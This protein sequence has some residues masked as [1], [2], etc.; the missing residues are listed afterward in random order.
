MGEGKSLNLHLCLNLRPTAGCEATAE[1]IL[2]RYAFTH[3]TLETE[4]D[5]ETCALA[6]E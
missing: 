3:Y 2:S 5:G 6:G 4:L 1:N